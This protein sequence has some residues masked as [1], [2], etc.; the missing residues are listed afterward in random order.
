MGKLS[1]YCLALL[2]LLNGCATVIGGDVSTAKSSG[3]IGPATIADS[4]AT[5]QNDKIASL[6]VAGKLNAK[7]VAIDQNLIV[8]DSAILNDVDVRGDSSIGGNLTA[9]SSTFDNLTKVG[10]NLVSDD[11]YFGNNLEFGGVNLQLV[12]KSIVTGNVLSTSREPTT[13]IIDRSTI[14]GDITFTNPSGVIIIRN[15]G[16]FKG[17]VINGVLHHE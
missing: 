6:T 3:S 15:R 12:H 5:L 17:E 13:I 1:K 14:R 2:I 7:K 8:R 16:V 4:D 10:G 11:S 9:L